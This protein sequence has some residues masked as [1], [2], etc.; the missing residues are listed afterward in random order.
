MPGK[1]N[2]VFHPSSKY[3]RYLLVMEKTYREISDELANKDLFDPGEE[4][5]QHADLGLADTCPL[6]RAARMNHETSM[7]Q[8]IAFQCG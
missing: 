3:I 7:T 8:E 6:Y 1:Y 5:L 2:I 4:Y